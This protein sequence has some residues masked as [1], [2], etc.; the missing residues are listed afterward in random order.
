L[1]GAA[2]ADDVA[3]MPQS[4]AA[5]ALAIAAALASAARADDP[6]ALSDADL[7]ADA[8]KPFDKDA[9]MERHVAL[10]QHHG[11]PVVA[12]FPC[13]DICPAYTIRIIH[14]DVAPGEACAKAGGVT[15]ARLVP[16]SI[17]VIEKD[18]CVPKVLAAGG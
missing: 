14:Y 4:L 15:Q 11:V 5:A 13:S 12:D 3:A 9:M 8:A 18:F 16:Y 10:G 2:L 7:V 1:T 6:P 17:A